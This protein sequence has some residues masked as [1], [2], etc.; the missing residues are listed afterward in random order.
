MP[1]E[2]E[3]NA[4]IAEIDGGIVHVQSNRFRMEMSQRD[5]YRM[6]VAI[7]EAKEQL[8]SSKHLN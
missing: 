8:A 4:P 1:F 6:A 5:F 2:V 7:N 3:I